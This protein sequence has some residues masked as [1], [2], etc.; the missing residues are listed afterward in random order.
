[1]LKQMLMAITVVNEKH[2][3][4]HDTQ[5]HRKLHICCN[6]IVVLLNYC[7]VS[8][9][10]TLTPCIPIQFLLLCLWLHKF[11]FVICFIGS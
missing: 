3:L 4:T 1:M 5:E 11:L 2:V 8:Q 10:C 9:S 7:L 6:H